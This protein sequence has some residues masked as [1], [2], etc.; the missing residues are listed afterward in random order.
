[1]AG[2]KISSGI[3]TP[4]CTDRFSSPGINR[5]DIWVFNHSEISAYG[6]GAQT[7]EISSLTF[8]P[9]YET[10]FAVAIH[11]NSGQFVEEL[12][13]SEEAA[14]FYNQTFSARIIANDTD[15]RNAIEDMVDVDLVIVF[16]LENGKFRIIGETGGVKL[17]EQTYDTG[18]TAGD[19]VGDT[20]VFT[21]VENG[22]ANF[23][24]DTDEDTTR[25]TLDS[26]L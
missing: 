18:K 26:Y 22:K 2:C 8:S 19:A 4:A 21:G 5:E 17:T 20:L 23:F 24:L 7:G 3:T 11:K 12:Q 25:T 16:K 1:M 10:G 15:T 14:P 9:S 13:T 6:A